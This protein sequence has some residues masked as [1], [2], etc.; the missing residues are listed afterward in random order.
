MLIGIIGAG[1]MGLGIAQQFASI[2]GN[3]ILLCSSSYESSIKGLDKI[4]NFLDEKIKKKKI[5]IER[6]NELIGRIQVSSI[7]ECKECDFI[8]ESISENLEQKHL[9][10]Q[11]LE[12]IC[13]FDSIFIT[14]TSSLSI[15]EIASSIKHEVIGMHFFNPVNAMKLVEIT[16]GLNTSD[17]C[18]KKC[19]ELAKSIGKTPVIVKENAGFIVNRILIPMINEAIGLYSEGI[20]DIGCIDSAMKLGANHPMGPLELGDL[21]GLDICLAIMEVIYKETGDT[22]YRPHPLLRK[23]VRGGAL[24]VKTAK[25]FYIYNNKTKTPNEFLNGKTYFNY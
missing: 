14:N 25:G 17:N 4:N 13:K 23:M 6:K 21:I 18:I 15:T 2:D 5:S 9:L 10:F 8:I 7:E 3:S 16:P 11:Q 19:L 22:K 1:T 12:N 24:G 20:A